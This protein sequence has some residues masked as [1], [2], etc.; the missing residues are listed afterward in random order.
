MAW[1]GIDDGYVSQ[2]VCCALQQRQGGPVEHGAADEVVKE[3]HPTAGQLAVKS[4]LLHAQLAKTGRR[5]VIACFCGLC[6]H[7]SGSQ[8]RSFQLRLL[9]GDGCELH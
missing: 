3:S 9:Q 1:K 6:C 7:H 8:P 2:Q 5:C 4:V